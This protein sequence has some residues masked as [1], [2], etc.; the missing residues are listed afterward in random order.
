MST[1]NDRPD[2]GRNELRLQTELHWLE[3]LFDSRVV[4]TQEF[5]IRHKNHYKFCRNSGRIK[6]VHPSLWTFNKDW[7]R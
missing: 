1:L 3:S 7:Y 4:G 5:H 2:D 6:K